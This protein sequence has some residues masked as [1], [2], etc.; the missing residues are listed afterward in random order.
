M[1]R[2]KLVNKEE[3][4]I[5]FVAL[6]ILLLL[7]IV[8]YSGLY[9]GQLQE[10]MAT[11]TGRGAVKT[12]QAAESLIASIEATVFAENAEA[13]YG[14]YTFPETPCTGSDCLAISMDALKDIAS[15]KDTGSGFKQFDING[16]ENTYVKVQNLGT[17]NNVQ[18][19]NG[20]NYQLYRVTAVSFFADSKSAIESLIALPVKK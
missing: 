2:A 9:S 14:T 5:L 4:M 7:S 1:L 10:S 12:D 6:V 8:V 18:G 13:A 20:A 15:V 17:S 3:G 19:G 16:V 11:D